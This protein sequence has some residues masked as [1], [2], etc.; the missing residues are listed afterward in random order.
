MLREA[1]LS[2]QTDVSIHRLE[3]GELPVSGTLLPPQEGLGITPTCSV[4]PYMSDH[5]N[6]IMTFAF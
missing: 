1:L 6:L 2:L 4:P 3:E 5:F